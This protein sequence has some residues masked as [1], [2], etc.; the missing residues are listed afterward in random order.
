MQTG[1][2]I[3]AVGYDL[4]PPDLPYVEQFRMAADAGFRS[5]E[6]PTVAD[7]DAAREVKEASD[8]TGLRIHSV[9]AIRAGRPAS[10]SGDAEETEANVV[11]TQT[12]IENAVLWGADVVLLIPGVIDARTNFE[13]AHTRSQRIIRERLLPFAAAHEVTLGIENVWRGFLLGPLEYV[14]YIDDFESPWVRAYLDVGNMI[15]GFPEHWVRVCGSR[16][17]RLHIK[18]FRMRRALGRFHFAKLGDGGI[19][20]VR[21]RHALRD[22]GYAG[23][24]TNTGVPLGPVAHWSNRVSRVVHRRHDGRAVKAALA[25]ASRLQKG[26]YARFLR[27]VSARFERFEV[28]RERP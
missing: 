28:L 16:I 11:A 14:R 13:Q 2:L 15:F 1:T 24:V 22:V 17:V 21:V 25:A 19:D 7:P 6:M 20:W 8:K 4:L 9:Q 23:H 27:D 18:D 12:S 3:N 5:I 10:Y 26:T